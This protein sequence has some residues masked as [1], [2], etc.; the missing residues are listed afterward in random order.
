MLGIDLTCGGITL[1]V[2]QKYLCIYYRYKKHSKTTW[3]TSALETN[4]QAGST[5]G[6]TGS[7]TGQIYITTHLEEV[8][9]VVTHLKGR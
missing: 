4:L 2:H 3:G 7:S 9:S 6:E 5:G 1:G 8:C